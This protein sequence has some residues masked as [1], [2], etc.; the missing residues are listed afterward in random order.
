MT[1]TQE[2]KDILVAIRSVK[3]RA[4]SALNLRDNAEYSRLMGDLVALNICLTGATERLISEADLFETVR[5]A[6]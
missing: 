3:F 6:A 5:N 2:V 1:V 4:T